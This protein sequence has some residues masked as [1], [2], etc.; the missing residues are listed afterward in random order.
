VKNK[1]GTLR[2]F[3]DFRQ[4]NKMTIKKKYPLPRIDDLFDQLKDAR[5]FSKI[6]LR[7]RYH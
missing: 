3:I 5:V 1:D 2:L 6:D 7:S 4:M